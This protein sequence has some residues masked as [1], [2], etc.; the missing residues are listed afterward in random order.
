MENT[1][2]G[3]AYNIEFNIDNASLGK[4]PFIQS[5]IGYLPP[6]QQRWDRMNFTSD[7]EFN[8]LMQKP[9]EIVVNYKDSRSTTYETPFSLNLR[10]YV[11][12]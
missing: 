12:S 9:I 1:G 8:E 3:P 10:E 7:Q 4:I 5:G 11:E 2:V 6:G